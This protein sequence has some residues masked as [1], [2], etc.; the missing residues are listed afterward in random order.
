MK[1]LSLNSTK[2]GFAVILWHESSCIRDE[3][4]DIAFALLV[5]TAERGGDRVGNRG[6]KVGLRRQGGIF[7][8]KSLGS[9][10][11]LPGFTSQLH[12]LIAMSS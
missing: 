10:V 3:Q 2:T 12:H 9:G 1:E 4:F 5:F 8:V 7:A 11:R 6:V